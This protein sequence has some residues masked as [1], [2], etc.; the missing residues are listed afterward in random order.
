MKLLKSVDSRILAIAACFLW[1]TAFA[2]VK[3]GLEAMPPL[4]FAGIRFMAAGLTVAWFSR[5]KRVFRQIADH[6]PTVLLVGFLQTF[7]LYSLF[8]YS[9]TMMRASTGAIVNGVGPLIVALTAHLTLKGNKLSRVQMICLFT[10]AAGVVLVALSGNA[11]AGVD[12]TSEMKGIL[13]M[14]GGILGSAVA[15]VIVTKS[16]DTL[17]PFVLN[18]GQLIT[19]SA[20]LLLAALIHGDRPYHGM[21]GPEFWIALIWL[22]FVTGGGFS[23]WFY[24]LKVRKE[25][26]SE[27]AVWRFLIPL[28]GAVISWII[29]RTDNPDPLS[30]TGMALTAL[31]IYIFYKMPLS[32]QPRTSVIPEEN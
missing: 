23:L 1:A 17:D 10:G 26:L 15:S 30:L 24:I 27:M 11:G 4:L 6:W 29:I 21:P 9:L 19:G 13:L 7:V 2:W 8:F 18:A 22:I 28:G 14:L 16:A 20:G 5:K 32:G 25:P 12:G 31:S 3:T